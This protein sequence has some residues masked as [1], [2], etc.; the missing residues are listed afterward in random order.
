MLNRHTW[1]LVDRWILPC[2]EMLTCWS[3][4]KQSL[5]RFRG[6][7]MQSQNC[8]SEDHSSYL[9]STSIDRTG[10]ARADGVA[11][12]ASM[13]TCRKWSRRASSGLLS[14]VP[15]DVSAKPSSHLGENSIHLAYRSRRRE[16]DGRSRHAPCS[17]ATED[18]PDRATRTWSRDPTTHPRTLSSR[19]RRYEL[20]S[21]GRGG[22][23]L[24]VRRRRRKR[25][26]LR[27]RHRLGSDPAQM[28]A[29]FQ[30]FP[31]LRRRLVGRRF[32]QRDRPVVRQPTT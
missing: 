5:S 24:L 2:A 7:V 4:P 12:S 6:Q 15:G 31:R 20:G 9:A 21:H 22:G 13:R 28:G 1:E 17:G 29:E 11:A 10:P 8:L 3:Y 16:P 19:R 30:R 14:A 25:T 32:A 18:V 26:A 23:R 27:S